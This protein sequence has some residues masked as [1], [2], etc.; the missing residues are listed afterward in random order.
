MDYKWIYYNNEIYNLGTDS[1]IHNGVLSESPK[2]V[3]P[4]DSNGLVHY[5]KMFHE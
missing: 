5:M 4:E 1:D 2:Y 3:S